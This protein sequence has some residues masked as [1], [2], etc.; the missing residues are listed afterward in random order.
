MAN[1]MAIL[2]GLAGIGANAATGAAT[3]MVEG[4][5]LKRKYASQDVLT[6][7][8]ALESILK[9]Q[10]I[11]KGQTPSEEIHSGIRYSRDPL[12]G[13][14][15]PLGPAPQ[16]PMN[17][18]QS[19]QA[20]AARARAARDAAGGTK[21]IDQLEEKVRT[22]G[23]ESLTPGERAVWGAHH[24]ADK[25][26]ASILGLINKIND[27]NTPPAE[28]ARAKKEL[29]DYQKVQAAGKENTA[30]LLH[31]FQDMRGGPWVDRETGQVI[32]NISRKEFMDGGGNKRYKPITANQQQSLD[33]L[34]GTAPQ[35]VTYMKYLAP[36]I[37]ARY[38]GQNLAKLIENQIKGKLSDTEVRE[39]GQLRN[40]LT[41]EL[42]RALS[43]T[44]AVRIQ[45]M[46]NLEEHALPGKGDRAQTAVN[47][48]DNVQTSIDNAIAG[49]KGMT[50]QPYKGMPRTIQAVNEKGEPATINLAPYEDLPPGWKPVMKR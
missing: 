16:P 27:P 38:P 35:M 7:M 39:Y 26:P 23:L 9:G 40:E 47:M 48:L 3:G 19:A 44:P 32:K 36:R 11:Q 17:E 41:I 13:T 5:E 22:G 28:R 34:E 15:T 21:V 14:L 31:G 10:Q 29:E 1:P 46:K 24:K 33:V 6:Q 30:T 2:A 12:K 49:I 50:P 4:E 42:G 43:G 18:L 45:I 25:E 8:H 37:L 20:A